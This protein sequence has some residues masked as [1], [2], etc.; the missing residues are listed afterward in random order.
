MRRWRSGYPILILPDDLEALVRDHENQPD[1][2]ELGAAVQLD[3]AETLM[4]D[5]GGSD[6]LDAGYIP[7]DRPYGLDEDNVTTAGMIEG[8]SLDERLAREE[9]ESERTDPDRS[10]RLTG[11]GL[12][13]EAHDVGIDGGAASAEEAAVHTVV[14]EAPR[15]TEPPLG[16]AL[17]DPELEASLHDDPAACIDAARIDAAR[18]A[19]GPAR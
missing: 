8:D 19:A 7:P 9:P 17:D 4:G 14:E 2:A 15:E 6:A 5:A 11:T 1:D 16:R 18:D 10:G 3:N 12:P 13:G